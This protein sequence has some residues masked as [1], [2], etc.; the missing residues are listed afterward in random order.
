LKKA[1]ER[2]MKEVI[3]ERYPVWAERLLFMTLWAKACKNRSPLPW[4]DFFIVARQLK[5][6]T[7]P[8]EAPLLRAVAERSI[9]SGIRRM[10]SDPK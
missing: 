3:R 5:Q 6:S 4:E 9:L 2:I 1:T 10:E 8:E 7:A